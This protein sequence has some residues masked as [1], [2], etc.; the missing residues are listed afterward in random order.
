[1]RTHKRVANGEAKG[2]CGYWHR[3]S[4]H[5]LTVKELKNVTCPRCLGRIAK[6]E[7]AE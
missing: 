1:M 3:G 5:G 7:K 6:K 2:V 4:G